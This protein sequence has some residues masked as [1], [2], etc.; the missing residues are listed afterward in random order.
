[1]TVAPT[2]GKSHWIASK[3]PVLIFDVNETL[4]DIDPMTPLFKR[5]FADERVLR[6]WFGHLVMYSMTL[7]GG[8]GHPRSEQ[9]RARRCRRGAEARARH[10]YRPTPKRN[11]PR[12]HHDP[13]GTHGAVP[14]E[15]DPYDVPADEPATPASY[16]ARTA[17][18]I[19]VEYVAGGVPLPETPPF[20][21]P[22]C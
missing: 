15:L 10:G 7:A 5:V 11:E 8:C 3:P 12:R 14:Q 16:A 22:D 18:E 20:L 4:I 6:E 17:V 19:S 2:Q 9:V 21:G 1:M 13:A